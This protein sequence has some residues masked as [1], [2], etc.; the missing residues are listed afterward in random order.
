MTPPPTPPPDLHDIVLPDPVSWAPQTAGWW[1]V[2]GL[3]TLL[4]LW[5]VRAAVHRRQANRYRPA[6]AEILIAFEE[7][8]LMGLL[9]EARSILGR[10][11]HVTDRNGTPLVRFTTSR[12]E[13][14]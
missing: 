12:R 9:Q 8:G 11:L 13:G 1:V 2:L 7:H 14:S 4:L 3:F 5:A 6:L 10:A